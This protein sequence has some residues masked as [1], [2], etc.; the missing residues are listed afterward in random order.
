LSER[1]TQ[2]APPP[3]DPA[4]AADAAGSVDLGPAEEIERLLEREAEMRE[5]VPHIAEQEPADA[6]DVIERLEPGQRSEVIHLLED[7]AA[8]GAL[9]EIES[10]FATAILLGLD[11]AEQA[12]IVAQMEPDDAADL[13]QN[14]DEPDRRAILDR[15]EPR[16]AAILGKLVLHD[17]ETAGGIMTTDIA[18]VRAQMRIGQAIDFLKRHPFLDEQHD[19]FVVDDQKRLVGTI[20]QRTL[21]V[22]DDRERVA[23]HMDEDFD[24]VGPEI[25][26]EE[27]A[28]IFARYD[29]LTLPVV[30]AHQRILGMIT[31]DDVLDILQ[32]E[33]TEDAL[34]Q[35]GAGEEEAVYSS[36]AT[37]IRGRS[38]W[39]LA[40][41]LFAQAGSVVLIL[42]ADLIEAIPL[43]AILYPIIANQSGNSGHQSMAIT[44]RGIVLGEIR[45]ER[46]WPLIRRELAFGLATGLG[47]G[48]VF[49][50][51]ASL[52]GPLL[53]PG[54]APGGT[55]WW[56]IGLVSGLAMALAL[57][58]SCMV[59]VGVPM[60]MKRLG[61]DPAT[62]SSIFVT[63]LTDALSYATFLTLVFVLLPR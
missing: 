51:G 27:V 19:V 63:M 32:A 18:V 46:V 42:Y 7:K 59:G 24:A 3:D 35:V 25:D 11:A 8:A 2:P 38:P 47:I 48:L 40:N 16:P 62:A 5:L 58:V 30:D 52:L 13:L 39:L 54:Q 21:L 22:T 43:V 36:I 34:K 55:T 20:T 4:D 31:I 49:G 33:A 23:D 45:P 28:H 1:P 14:L 57:A 26:R 61:F 50:V 60:V 17:P 29:L 6:A 37:K 44:L 53:L 10:P 9:S 41:L 12:A 56:A 15:L